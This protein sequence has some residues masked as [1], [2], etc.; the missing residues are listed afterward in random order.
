MSENGKKISQDEEKSLYEGLGVDPGKRTVREIFKKLIDNEYPKAFVNIVTDPYFPERV[1]T[2]HQD[3]DGSK[4]I[5]R[6]LQF[7]E[8][9][10]EEVFAGM[11][12][13]ALSMN[14]GDIAAAGFV[15]EPWVVT[16]VLNVNLPNDLKKIVMKAV[17]LRLL[18]LREDY[19]KYGDFSIKFLGGETADL[20]DQVK[21]AVFDM[22][23]TAW[24]NKKDLIAGEVEEGDLI[25]GFQSNGKAVWEKEENSGIMSNGLTLARSCLMSTEFNIK[26][27]DLKRVTADFYKGR[28]KPGDQVDILKGMS[29][30]DAILSPTRQWAIVIK[31]LILNLKETGSLDKLHGI[32]MNTGGGCTKIKHIGEGI[33]YVKDKMP[34]APPIFQLIKLESGENWKN[35]YKSF[36]CGIGIDIVGKNDIDFVKAI[37]KTAEEV[38]LN[39]FELGSCYKNYDSE[40]EN[41]VVIKTS[42]ESFEY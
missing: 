14:T 40:K 23:I 28:F 12:D 6:I 11:A 36:N 31:K 24:C 17:A 1:L 27:P 2:Q 10:E 21:S 39:V 26:Y 33:L 22:A 18:E 29:V 8:N 16:D 41:K 5:Q 19:K 7:L 38:G 37:K 25:F 4:F 30:G 3:G 34:L 42:D 13:D 32:T 35:M 9:G 15:F 20:P